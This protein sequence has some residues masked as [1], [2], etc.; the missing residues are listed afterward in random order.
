VAPVICS[1]YSLH[2]QK[3]GA[4]REEEHKVDM[5]PS[6]FSYFSPHLSKNP[7]LKEKKNTKVG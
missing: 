6:I 5:A 1:H 3:A 2:K 7:G 4:E